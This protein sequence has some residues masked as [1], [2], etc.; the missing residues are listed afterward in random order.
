MN[1]TP[2]SPTEHVWPKH[3]KKPQRSTRSF[4]DDVGEENEA[5]PPRAFLLPRFS[6]FIRHQRIVSE[7]VLR[8][9]KSPSSWTLPR[10]PPPQT[11][12]TDLHAESQFDLRL[13]RNSDETPEDD[14]EDQFSEFS[15]QDSFHSAS[16][17][18][19]T[20]HV[21]EQIYLARPQRLKL[22]EI[23][24]KC[25]RLVVKAHEGEDPISVVHAHNT[26]PDPQGQDQ[27]IRSPR[28]FVQFDKAIGEHFGPDITDAMSHT[29]STP[30]RR[31]DAIWMPPVSTS[32]ET[33]FME[34]TTSSL[35]DLTK[36]VPSIPRSP[37]GPQA[38]RSPM[39]EIRRSW[40]LADQWLAGNG[41]NEAW[42]QRQDGEKLLREEYTHGLGVDT[43]D[44]RPSSGDQSWGAA[45]PPWSQYVDT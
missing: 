16:E 23:L 36:E 15:G 10:S 21:A 28:S 35:I 22:I 44:R 27:S 4:G 6:R 31:R 2:V 34:S 45:R 33:Q 43:L 29:S 5:V 39:E 8:V 25:R 3:N 19:S 7:N 14:I 12:N 37:S 9:L 18:D 11:L 42:G 30:D 26:L 40:A 38:S 13:H 24:P 1:Q 41:S 17:D 32:P 20:V